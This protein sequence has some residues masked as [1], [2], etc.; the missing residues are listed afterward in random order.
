MNSKNTTETTYED[1]VSNLYNIKVKRD[2]VDLFSLI[3]SKEFIHSDKTGPVSSWSDYVA[4]YR[5]KIWQE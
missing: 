1:F 4:N 3:Y 2:I 5:K